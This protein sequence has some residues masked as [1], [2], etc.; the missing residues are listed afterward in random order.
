MPMNLAY[1]LSQTNFRK[2]KVQMETDES[3]K[4]CHLNV[5]K[6]Q[7]WRVPWVPTV[8]TF[9]HSSYLVM[10]ECVKNFSQHF[11]GL[12]RNCS[13]N[14]WMC[15]QTFLTFLKQFAKFVK[16][17]LEAP[18]FLIIDN[19][20][21]HIFLEGINYFREK[22]IFM[23]WI[24]PHTSSWLQQIL[25]SCSFKHFFQRRVRCSY[26]QQSRQKYWG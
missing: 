14:R 5:K 12:R 1:S 10:C 19:H 26:G 4:L 25:N 8:N 15:T 21:S 2:F 24:P 20:T 13:K 6:T 9:R 17:S 3:L 18:A 7:P 11:H 23:F 22:G 16:P